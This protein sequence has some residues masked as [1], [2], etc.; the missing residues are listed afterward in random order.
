MHIIIPRLEK[1]AVA[2]LSQRIN[3][4]IRVGDLARLQT[5]EM[6]GLN[7]ISQ[8]QQSAQTSNLEI[9][10]L[11]EIIATITT[12]EH[13]HKHQHQQRAGFPIQLD[14]INQTC[15]LL[16]HRCQNLL[17]STSNTI[18]TSNNFDEQFCSTN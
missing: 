2:E 1:L 5:P 4:L 12:K 6:T 7:D 13:Q 16:C 14:G 9:E 8:R 10:T 15:P 3:E 11:A 18:N 17:I